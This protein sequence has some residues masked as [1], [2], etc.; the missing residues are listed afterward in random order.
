[1]GQFL[2]VKVIQGGQ[3]QLQ[4]RTGFPSCYNFDVPISNFYGGTPHRKPLKIF[5][6]GGGVVQFKVQMV[7]VPP[8]IPPVPISALC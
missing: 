2:S 6:M 3:Y 5:M 7:V 1:M 8:T 4:V